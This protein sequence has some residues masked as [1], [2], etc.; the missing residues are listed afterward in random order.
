MQ[1]T[2]PLTI[3]MPGAGDVAIPAAVRAGAR[4]W[5]SGANALHAGD[6]P[7]CARAQAHLALDQLEAALTSVGGSL[8]DVTKLTTCVVDRGYRAA[9]YG[10]IAERIQTSGRPVST[11]LVVAGLPDPALMVQIDAEAAICAGRSHVRSYDYDNWFGQGFA[12]RGSMVVVTPDEF[13]VRGQTGGALDHSGQKAAGRSLDTARQLA[14]DGLANLHQLLTEAGGGLEDVA[15]INVYLADRRYREAIYPEIGRAFGDIH[16]CSTGIV[17][18]AFAREDI[19]WEID[20]IAPRRHDAAP[21]RRHR[22]Y[23]SASARYGTQTQGL[24][25]RFCMIVEAGDRIILR[26]QTG[27]TLDERLV[28]AGCVVTQTGQAMDNVAQLLSEAGAELG[29]VVKAVVY[30]T[31]GD[32]V[33]P[34]TRAVVDRFGRTLPALTTVVVKGLASPELLMEIDITAVRPG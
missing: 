15:R 4:V 29:D 21:H 14:R 24:D 28:G 32:F 16:P 17:T 12:W 22:R 25:C 3:P 26:G 11:G 7:A 30:V 19:L 18:T 31:E 20:V 5:L 13:F 27:M 9:V 2:H 1:R 8:G 10:A 34:V 23:H 6:V 33:A